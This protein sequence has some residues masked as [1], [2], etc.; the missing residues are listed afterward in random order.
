MW[1]NLWVGPPNVRLDLLWNWILAPFTS[2]ITA[3]LIN[4]ILF[5]K[6]QQDTNTHTQSVID[7][8][9]IFK[10]CMNKGGKFATKF[11]YL[12]FRKIVK[13][14]ATRCQILR[15]KCNKFDFGWNSAPDPAGELTALPRPPSWIL[16]ALLLRGREGREREGKE[17]DGREGRRPSYF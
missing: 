10:F 11:C 14:V 15:Q 5:V 1:C 12:I 3:L 16:R 7:Y 13:I 4:V 8:F 9:N 2:N 17:E 6:M